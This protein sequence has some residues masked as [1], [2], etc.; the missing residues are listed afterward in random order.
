MAWIKDIH[1]NKEVYSGT[2]TNEFLRDVVLPMAMAH[3][4]YKNKNKEEAY[5]Y[6]QQV[7]AEDWRLAGKQ[8]L[9]RRYNA[10]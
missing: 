1:Q 8:W 6:I 7:I 5:Q 10:R 9:D 2:L 3:Q 4:C